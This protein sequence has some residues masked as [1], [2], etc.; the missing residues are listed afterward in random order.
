MFDSSRLT[1]DDLSS[2]MGLLPNC[3]RLTV[4]EPDN[5]GSIDYIVDQGDIDLPSSEELLRLATPEA[6]SKK[7]QLRQLAFHS[8]LLKLVDRKSAAVSQQSSIDYEVPRHP[9]ESI[10]NLQKK[11]QAKNVESILPSYCRTEPC[12]ARTLLR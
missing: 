7:L 6:I 4:S 1:I 3:Y 2:M 8:A 5:S 12:L 9:V 11:Q 10:A